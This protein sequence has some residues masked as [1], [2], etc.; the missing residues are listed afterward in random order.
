MNSG[1]KS[2]EKKLTSYERWKASHGANHEVESDKGYA[3]TSEE[4][5][6]AVKFGS[7]RNLASALHKSLILDG[8]LKHVISGRDEIEREL[9]SAIK[10]RKKAER[11][12]L[13]ALSENETLREKLEAAE[14]AREEAINLTN[15]VHA[16]NL[17]LDHD[18]TFLKAVLEDT[19]RVIVHCFFTKFLSPP[20]PRVVVDDKRNLFL[21]CSSSSFIG[22]SNNKRGSIRGEDQIF[23]TTGICWIMLVDL[24]GHAG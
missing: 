17:R 18:L 6:S 21:Y 2:G 14:L 20:F 4:R 19:Q 10:C 16:E 3:G 23:S 5:L 24:L 1:K 7:D 15:I 13:V 8:E 22:A 12:L 11:R 9:A